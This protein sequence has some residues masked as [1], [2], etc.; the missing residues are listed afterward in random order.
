[1]NDIPRLDA[2]N[3]S[4][5]VR[6]AQA[7]FHRDTVDEVRQAVERDPVVVVGMAQNPVVKKARRNLE[8]AGIDFTYLE[9]GSYFSE[10]RRRLAVKLWSGWPTFPQVFVRGALIGGNQ[11]TEAALADGSLRARLAAD[12]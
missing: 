6:S 10:W 4:D 11:E 5:K 2:E 9:Y 1:M 8:A 3:M 12:A 7:D